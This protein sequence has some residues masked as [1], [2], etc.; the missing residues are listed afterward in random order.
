M[1]PTS[2]DNRQIQTTVE[3]ESIKMQI[4]AESIEHIVQILTDL[5][6]D[7]E[8]AI[9]REV[10]TNALDSHIAAGQT[11]PIEVSVPTAL[12]QVFVVQD[13][14]VGLNA[15]DLRNL[16]SL[17][18]KSTKTKTND[19][20]GSLGLGCKSP[21]TYTNQFTVQGVK[22][23]IKT[24]ALVTRDEDGIPTIEIPEGA[25]SETDEPNGVKVVI[26]TK[27]YNNIESKA[28][29]LYRH[30]PEAS[31]L[32]NGNVPA[33]LQ[34]TKITET[35]TQIEGNQSYVVMCNVPY[36]LGREHVDAF[37]NYNQSLVFKVAPGEVHFTP[38]REGLHLTGRTKK[39][40]ERLCAEYKEKALE[41]AQE[42]VDKA[43]TRWEALSLY[44][45]YRNELRLLERTVMHGMVTPGALLTYKDEAFPTSIHA[46]KHM[47]PTTGPDPKLTY[48]R[49]APYVF[50]TTDGHSG[51]K[52]RNTSYIDATNAPDTLW[53]YGYDKSVTPT[54]K[55]K[56]WQWLEEQG[57]V[58]PSQMI[59]LEPQ[60]IDP[61]IDPKTVVPWEPISVIKLPRK[62]TTSGWRAAAGTYDVYDES[63]HVTRQVGV[64]EI[65]DE[66]TDNT[67]LLY[68]SSSQTAYRM[69][70]AIKLLQVYDAFQIAVV[71]DNRLNKF[72]RIFPQA[73]PVRGH[74]E[75]IWKV[76][77]QSLGA[78][79]RQRIALGQSVRGRTIG[80]HVLP[81]RVLDPEL[82]QLAILCRYQVPQHI[83]T[84]HK[85]FENV[86]SV[87]PLP[88][89]AQMRTRYPL[90]GNPSELHSSAKLH[91]T[92][93]C[94]AIYKEF[95]ANA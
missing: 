72:K 68:C 50:H 24:S 89:V 39:T 91:N 93:Y 44:Y 13:W 94:N 19:Q 59:F 46:P 84:V 80:E 37:M 87:G 49:E 63:G 61:W 12:S 29:Q 47:V 45:R 88:L 54:A 34:G 71:Y 67:P 82:R 6:S 21:L 81:S 64:E 5:Y 95:Y 85:Q 38:S 36:P 86:G 4:D 18:G 76:W 2:T 20:A 35:I 17:Y 33:K 40:I 60:M 53:I 14:G 10:S 75:S 28:R 23:G 32:L 83:L 74:I 3:G 70:R 69:S 22:D 25:I 78:I 7:P 58:K 62:T 31:V 55:K 43:P 42:A 9:V 52:E 15:D 51:F 48:T 65:E 66:I 16:Y 11:K 92:I 8:M 57:R 77:W 27:R 73:Q 1:I 26:P 41:A 56:V 90:A 79:D 30:W